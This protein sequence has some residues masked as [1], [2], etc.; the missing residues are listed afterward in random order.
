M[1]KQ[2]FKLVPVNATE[3]AQGEAHVVLVKSDSPAEAVSFVSNGRP[4][5]A[6]NLMAGSVGV[7]NMNRL[8]NPQSVV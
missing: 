8:I 4:D 5:W 6:M 1:T 3:V 7:F 2:F